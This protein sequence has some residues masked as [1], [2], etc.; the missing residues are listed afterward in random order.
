MRR[1]GTALWLVFVAAAVLAAGCAPRGGA[2]AVSRVYDFRDSD[3]GWS[4]GFCDLPVGYEP[5]LYRLEFFHGDRPP[6]TGEG[7]ALVLS[8]RNASDDLFMFVKKQLTRED[9]IQP[10]TAYRV[11]VAVTVATDAPAGAMGVGGPPGEAV[12]FKVGAAA[13][14][15]V[16]VA[17]EEG[18]HP[19]YV[20]SVDKGRQN[21]DGRDA[22]RIGDAAKVDN[23]EFGVYEKKTLDNRDVPLEVTSDGDGALWIFVGTDS[24]FEGTTTLYY[25][26]IAVELEPV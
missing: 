13:Q 4:G 1:M 14:E 11:R 8:G 3:H 15:P 20:L 9:G 24:G 26:E 25:T 7:K 5:D 16:A 23:Q 10:D 6:E 21:E 22:L 18:P 17:E 2:D 12:W 19:H